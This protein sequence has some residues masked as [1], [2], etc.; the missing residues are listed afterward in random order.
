MSEAKT[1]PELQGM[2]DLYGIENIPN[3]E[4]YPMRFAFLVK[5]Y[6]YYTMKQAQKNSKVN[7]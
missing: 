6:R 5:S 4:Q 2:I 3:P 1:D 7:N